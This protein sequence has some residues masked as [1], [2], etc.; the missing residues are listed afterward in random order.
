MNSNY[1]LGDF[2]VLVVLFVFA[3]W[4]TSCSSPKV[5]T[6]DGYVKTHCRLKR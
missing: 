5:L 2:G 1:T 3:V 6:G 4:L